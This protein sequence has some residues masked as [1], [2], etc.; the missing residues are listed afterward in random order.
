MISDALAQG[1]TVALPRFES[2][3][4]QYAAVQVT[5]VGADLV[6]GRYGIL[7]PAGHC[8]P[9][10]VKALDFALV[11]G[12][13]FASDGCRL[14]RGKGYYDRLLAGVEGWKCGIG[15]DFQLVAEVPADD[16]DVRLDSLLTPVRWI[17]L[18]QPPVLK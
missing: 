2:G 6:A 18:N 7:E 1:K 16:R 3:C 14:G 9:L 17:E 8:P 13:A 5:N 11:P 15:Y 12:V 10:N 4:N